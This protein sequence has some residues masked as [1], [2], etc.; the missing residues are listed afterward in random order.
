MAGTNWV[1]IGGIAQLGAAVGTLVLAGV[2]AWLAKRTHEMAAEAKEQ[3]S[4]AL[5]EAEATERLAIE[6]STDRQLAWRPN[7]G[8]EA[9]TTVSSSKQNTATVTLT[10]VGNG[11]ALD[12]TIWSYRGDTQLW[13]YFDNFLLGPH[14]SRTVGVQLSQTVPNRSFPLGMFDPPPGFHHKSQWIYVVTCRD[15]LD[16]RWRFMAGFPPDVVQP[17]Q[18]SPPGW[19]SAM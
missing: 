10:N 14:E 4:A 7:V 18:V 2:T 19:T 9:G 17:G 3:A 6:A 15:V 13:G 5:R 1:E 11:P 8:I 12:C 16:N